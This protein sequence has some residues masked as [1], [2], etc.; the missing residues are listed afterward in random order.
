M[1]IINHNGSVVGKVALSLECTCCAILLSA[2]Y[3]PFS[4]RSKI[5]IIT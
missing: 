2:C 3:I 4:L 5:K 1:G